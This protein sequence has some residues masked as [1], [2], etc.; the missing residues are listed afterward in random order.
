MR[1]SVFHGWEA[2]MERAL[3]ISNF[4]TFDFCPDI[5]L[6]SP[7]ACFFLDFVNMLDFTR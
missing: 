3:A 7:V 2:E 6:P 1:G 4:Q 5:L